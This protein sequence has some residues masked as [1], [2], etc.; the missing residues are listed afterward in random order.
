MRGNLFNESEFARNIK[1]QHDSIGD[2]A[3][4]G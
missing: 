4:D 2:S 1:K 3:F